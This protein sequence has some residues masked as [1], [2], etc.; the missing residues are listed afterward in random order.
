MFAIYL[1]G[2]NSLILLSMM[3]DFFVSISVL[4]SL[5]LSYPRIRPWM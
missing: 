5:I 2:S 1:Y 3:V 4:S